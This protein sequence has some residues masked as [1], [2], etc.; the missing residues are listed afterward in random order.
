MGSTC[1][2]TCTSS[3]L[4]RASGLAGPFV[5]LRGGGTIT[6]AEAGGAMTRS[7]RNAWGS[8]TGRGT[9]SLAKEM[10]ESCEKRDAMR[11]KRDLLS[12]NARTMHESVREMDAG[13]FGRE[14]MGQVRRIEDILMESAS[15][16]QDSYDEELAD[17]IQR[18]SSLKDDPKGRRRSPRG[19]GRGDGPTQG[20]GRDK[21][22][23]T[24]DER[25]SRLK[26]ELRELEE[27]QGGGDGGAQDRSDADNDMKGEKRNK[28]SKSSKGSARNNE[29]AA[30]VE[31]L[32]DG[33]WG[34][35]SSFSVS[36]PDSDDLADGHEFKQVDKDWRK[37]A[38]LERQ[39]EDLEKGMP[40]LVRSMAEEFNEVR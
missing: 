37:A 34:A 35:L 19:V 29:D 7:P 11:R 9:E 3:H 20:Q 39:D 25:L 4:P 5:R 16:D 26:R 6:G 17:T 13:S 38:A 40:A 24:K 28:Q 27:G 30:L 22:I 33:V 10:R 23:E 15:G 1:F 36:E 12:Q 8:E 14:G 18:H 21:N 32:D 2:R 31:E